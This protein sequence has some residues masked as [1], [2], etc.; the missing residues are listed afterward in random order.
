MSRSSIGVSDT[1]N[2][3][4]VSAN[5]IE[6]PALRRCREETANRDDANMQIGA[7]QGAFMAFLARLMG[8]RIYVEIGVFTGYS[9]LCMALA[10]KE[11]H[12]AEARIIACDKSEEFVDI[13]RGYWAEADVDDVIEARLGDG[14]NSL[15]ALGAE[16]LMDSVDMVFIDADKENSDAYYEEAATLLRP[17]GV[18]ILDNVLWSGKVADK[19]IDDPSTRALRQMAVK[20]KSD[21][22]F[23]QTLIS[24]GDGLLMLRKRDAVDSHIKGPDAEAG[25]YPPQSA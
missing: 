1:L 3:Y 11:M 2:D 7:E 19:E 24:V 14:L 4:I 25:R 5:R 16:G 17:G 6:P 13:A 12:G 15:K 9:A 23:D 22:R 8:A 18:M 21:G 10:M 20:A